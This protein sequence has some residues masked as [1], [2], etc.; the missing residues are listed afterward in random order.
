M[1]PDSTPS[2]PPPPSC[3]AL[4]G[5]WNLLEEEGVGRGRSSAWGSD[6]T[7]EGQRGSDGTEHEE[8]GRGR[9]SGV[10]VGQRRREWARGGAKG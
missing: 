10:V 8:V 7:G 9:S 4:S 6:G 3:L 2:L 5:P 1:L